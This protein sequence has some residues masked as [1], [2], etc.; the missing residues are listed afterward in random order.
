MNQSLSRHDP[1]ASRNSEQISSQI[2]PC[3]IR[4]VYPLGCYAVMP[5]FF[6]Q[7]E[8]IG[9]ENI[10][11]TGP[12]IVAPTHRS[13][14][15]ALIIPHAVGRL[16]S[17]RDLRFMVTSDEYNRPIQGWFIRQLGGFPVNVAR[18][19][20]GSLA[21]SIELL[22][23][24]EMLVIFPEGGIVRDTKVHR[25]KR[26]VARIALEV[27][28]GHPN[29]GVKILPI[30]VKYDS[31]YPSWGS[32]VTVKIGEPIDVANYSSASMKKSSEKLIG[33]LETSLRE[34]YEEPS[35][36]ISMAIAQD[37]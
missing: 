19:G 29:R 18:P 20:F 10:P 1:L 4:L 9:R 16:V 32:N 14:W 13:R 33:A 15:D 23:Q 31:F 25:L 22:S 30:A 36:A 3:L 21:H 17:G 6:G 24:G 28:S 7:I 34:L 2:N 37:F 5:L 8:V 26:G 12:A 35:H 11:K 27:E